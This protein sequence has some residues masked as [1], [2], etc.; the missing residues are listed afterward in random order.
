MFEEIEDA[1]F[2]HQSRH[3]LKI[4]LTILHAIVPRGVGTRKVHAE[5]AETMVFEYLRH[6]FRHSLF[7]KDP[8][9][10]DPGEKPKP[11]NYF[12]VIMCKPVLGAEVVA[13]QRD[14]A[15]EAIEETLRLVGQPDRDGNVLS[16]N[17][18]KHHL[19]RL[20]GNKIQAE[21]EHRR[22]RFMANQRRRQQ[23]VLAQ[24][25]DFNRQQTPSLRRL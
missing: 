16:D 14:T 19:L 23:H 6:N 11:G 18:I 12:D 2:F 3:K 13:H 4:A 10:G 17:L 21:R 9:V 20:L 24:R 8:A 1:F 22:Y 25:A 7:L 5:V 15:Y